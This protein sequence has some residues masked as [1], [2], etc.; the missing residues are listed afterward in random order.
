MK[1]VLW[2]YAQK[3]GKSLIKCSNNYNDYYDYNKNNSYNNNKN[4]NGKNIF[5]IMSK[6]YFWWSG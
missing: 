6:I 1:I 5:L 4:K 2:K 3:Y